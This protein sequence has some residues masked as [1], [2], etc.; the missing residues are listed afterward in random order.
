MWGRQPD[1]LLIPSASSIAA[2]RDAVL[3]ICGRAGR[4]KF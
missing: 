1:Q 2:G 4:V 3:G